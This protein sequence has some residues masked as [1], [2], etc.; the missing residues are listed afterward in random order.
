MNP[1]AIPPDEG[2]AHIRQGD[3]NRQ[4]FQAIIDTYADAAGIPRVEDTGASLRRICDSLSRFAQANF[5]PA[6]T[7]TSLGFFLEEGRGHTALI[8]IEP[9][10]MTEGAELPPGLVGVGPKI[11]AAIDNARGELFEARAGLEE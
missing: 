5:C 11:T 10:A 6:G 3:M 4:V 9:V 8:R 1:N 7:N 2:S